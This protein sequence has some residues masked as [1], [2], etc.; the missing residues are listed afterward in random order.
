M[1]D[2][3]RTYKVTTVA[4]VAARSPAEAV[5]VAAGGAGNGQLEAIYAEAVDGG[6]PRGGSAVERPY[7]VTVVDARTGVRE[8]DSR[9]ASQGSAVE[10]VRE[11]DRDQVDDLGRPPEHPQVEF[12]GVPV[13][14]S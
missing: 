3:E 8:V 14:V 12:D 7:A 9:H 5:A 4:Y 13:E 10:R 11:L 2:E 1:A 6:G